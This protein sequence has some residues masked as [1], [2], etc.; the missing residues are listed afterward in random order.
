MAKFVFEWA[1][2]G[3]PCGIEEILLQ[4]VFG[5]ALHADTL[6]LP[7][8]TAF[9]ALSGFLTLRQYVVTHLKEVT[10]FFNTFFLGRTILLLCSVVFG[11]RRSGAD[12]KSVRWTSLEKRVGVRISIQCCNALGLKSCLGAAY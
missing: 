3:A 1:G 9:A 11:T 7:N 6:E 5:K 10:T 12:S 8:G 2:S 4:D